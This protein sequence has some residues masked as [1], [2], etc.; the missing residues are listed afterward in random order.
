MQL[1]IYAC[2]YSVIRKI[3]IYKAV[4][5]VKPLYIDLLLYT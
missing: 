4:I 1:Y 2:M 5:T 3:N